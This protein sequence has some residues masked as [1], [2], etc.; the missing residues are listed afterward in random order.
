MNSLPV[1]FLAKF[2]EITAKCMDDQK[3]ESDACALKHVRLWGALRILGTMFIVSLREAADNA[4]CDKHFK[5][6]EADCY[7]GAEHLDS[8]PSVQSQLMKS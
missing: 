7:V 1:R 8:R 4:C 6:A 2:S 5:V 3:S